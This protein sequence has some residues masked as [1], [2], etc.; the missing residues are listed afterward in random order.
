MNLHAMLSLLGLSLLSAAALVRPAPE[1]I[2]GVW[3]STRSAPQLEAM[4][5]VCYARTPRCGVCVDLPIPPPKQIVRLDNPSMTYSHLVPYRFF[6]PLLCSREG[7]NYD[8]AP[9]LVQS[10]TASFAI[11]SFLFLKG[12][13][14]WL[15]HWP[16]PEH[17]LY[18][19]R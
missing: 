11:C 10:E 17:T 15:R 4:T 9:L 6:L 7:Y 2:W 14:P 13:W 3:R 5:A 1:P 12:A 19:R 16:H 8:Y 18:R